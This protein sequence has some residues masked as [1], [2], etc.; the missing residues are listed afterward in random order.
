MLEIIG[1]ILA[2]FV[3]LLSVFPCENKDIAITIHI[4]RFAKHASILTMNAYA[5]AGGF[6]MFSYGLKTESVYW[7]FGFLFM[8]TR[9]K[10]CPSAWPKSEWCTFF[11]TDSSRVPITVFHQIRASVVQFWQTKI[12][13]CRCKHS[14]VWSTLAVTLVKYLVPRNLR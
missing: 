6:F 14:V 9:N 13:T 10:Y 11:C 1:P 4:A 5:G 2:F 12:M 3:I 7:N 8:H